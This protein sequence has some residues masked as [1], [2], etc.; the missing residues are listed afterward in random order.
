MNEMET[1]LRSMEFVS[2][3]ELRTR[4]GFI[5]NSSALYMANCKATGVDEKFKREITNCGDLRK[6]Q[7]YITRRLHCT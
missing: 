3:L 4:T 1:I 7:L 5:N 6:T 2:L